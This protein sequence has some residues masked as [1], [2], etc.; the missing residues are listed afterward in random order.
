MNGCSATGRVGHV[1]RAIARI[2]LFSLPLFLLLQLI[3]QPELDDQQPLAGARSLSAK[4]FKQD[5]SFKSGS[6]HVLQLSLAVGSRLF[7]P[8]FYSTFVRNT[9]QQDFVRTPLVSLRSSRSPPRTAV[10]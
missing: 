2:F 8:G 5:H 1:G 7:T 9:R 4:I 6:T 10:A 3:G